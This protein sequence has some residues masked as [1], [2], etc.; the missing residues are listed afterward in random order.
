[1]TVSKW[2]RLQV[3]A[4]DGAHCRYCG[5]RC[6]VAGRDRKRERR[7]AAKDRRDRTLDHV[8]PINRGGGS[9][10][11]NV[12]VACA[13]CNVRKGGRTPEGAGMVLRPPPKESEP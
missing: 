12:V 7:V 2:T 10:V 13:R 5:E 11:D 6:A 3:F 4:R 8:I 1:V 9:G